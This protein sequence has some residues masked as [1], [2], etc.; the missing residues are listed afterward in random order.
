MSR[1]TQKMIFL[2]SR[3]LSRDPERAFRQGPRQKNKRDGEGEV[4]CP[5]GCG[6]CGKVG[7]PRPTQS[8][9]ATAAGT[10][11]GSNTTAT[12]RAGQGRSSTMPSAQLVSLGG[13]PIPQTSR[14][15]TPAHNS[16]SS[17]TSFKS[18]LMLPLHDLLTLS[19]VIPRLPPTHRRNHN[20]TVPTSSNFI[21]SRRDHSP[22][23]PRP[24]EVALRSMEHR[25]QPAARLLI[26]LVVNCL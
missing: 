14:I 18:G 23:Q 17:T 7:S 24:M 11:T 4:E 12:T 6:E 20:I 2:C 3:R 1:T 16:A 19:V 13:K 25:V 5:I 9:S 10:G 26:R 21:I 8:Q 22:L 15:S